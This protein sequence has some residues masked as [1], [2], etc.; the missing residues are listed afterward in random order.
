MELRNFLKLTGVA[1]LLVAGV[2]PCLRAD[3]GEFRFVRPYGGRTAIWR[4][5]DSFAVIG[6]QIYYSPA[7]LTSPPPAPNNWLSFLHPY[8]HAYVTVPVALPNG[9]PHMFQHTD[10][11]SFDYG[12]VSV[13]IHFVRDGSV[14]VSYNSKAP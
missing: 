12:S 4:P 9:M 5:R 14:G 2:V 10:R 3:D 8:T 1:S 6:G 13:V 11:V 7:D